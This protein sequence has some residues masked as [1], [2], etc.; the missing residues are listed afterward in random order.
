MRHV[1]LC[2]AIALIA[3]Q[4]AAESVYFAS[5]TTPPTPLQQRLARERG[6]ITAS[7]SDAPN[8][9]SFS[10]TTSNTTRAADRA[11]WA[12][13]VTALRAA[14]DGLGLDLHVG[15]LDDLLPLVDLVLQ[16][17]GRVGG[18]GA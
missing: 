2:L 9:S 14:F 17:P 15:G 16:E 10:A 5:A 3:T 12:E 7:I 18:R 11:A 6:A 4:A 13:T 1:L 8:R